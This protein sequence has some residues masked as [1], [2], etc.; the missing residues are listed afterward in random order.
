VFFFFFF[1]E[2]DYLFDKYIFDTN[3]SLFQIIHFGDL[4]GDHFA[5]EFLLHFH[6]RLGEF[7]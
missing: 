2:K 7:S 6:Q 1:K 4:F 3:N 5:P